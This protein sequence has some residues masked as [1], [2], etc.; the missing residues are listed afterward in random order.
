VKILFLSQLIPYPLDAGPR[1]RAYYVLRQLAE[2][3]DVTLACLSRADDGPQALNH[4]RTWCRAV[5]TIPIRR[6]LWRD[7]LAVAQG[8][9][10]RE[11]IVVRRDRSQAMHALVA[12]LCASER[13]DSVHA[14]QLPMAQFALAAPVRGKVLDEHNAV[15]RVVQRLARLEP[16]RWRRAVL[17]REWRALRRY[18]GEVCRR[19]DAVIAVS[20]IDQARLAEVG[21]GARIQIIPICTD[22][23]AVHA[24]RRSRE[25]YRLTYIGSLL[26]PPNVDGICW[27]IREVWS[28][29]LA[30]APAARLDIVGKRPPSIIRAFQS[31]SI[32]VH[33]YVKDLE[34]ILAESAVCIV[35]LRAG[36]GMRVRILEAWA[37]GLPVVSTTIGAEGI[38]VRDGEN[39]LLADSPADFAS[40]LIGLL[41]DQ[42][43]AERI[44]AAGRRW[45]RSR[46]NWRA[47]YQRFSAVHEAVAAQRVPA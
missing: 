19:F 47:V 4:L 42:P 40:A 41:N 46:Y 13:F 8:V 28:R 33:G 16:I 22:T 39:I 26:W 25:T 2:T 27:F 9:V 11:P 36:G 12:R 29:V 43:R 14:D 21:A 17:E 15:W 18:E 23:D 3:H 44:G 38:E 5:H 6:T 10:Q 37:R 24:I 34:P 30:A 45:V 7:A 35:P 31:A 1:I 32:N 20:E